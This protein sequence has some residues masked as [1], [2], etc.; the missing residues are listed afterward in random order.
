LSPEV[1][2]YLVV[3][4]SLTAAG[5]RRE[6]TDALLEGRKV[7]TLPAP[8]LAQLRARRPESVPCAACGRT[9]T[10]LALTPDPLWFAR[11]VAS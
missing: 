7:Y 10:V 11:R 8:N 3:K 5:F 4:H 1:C 9:D 6:L 2:H